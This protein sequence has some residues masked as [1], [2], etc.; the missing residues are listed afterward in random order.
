MKD[1]SVWILTLGFILTVHAKVIEV[2]NAQELIN[3]FTNPVSDEIEL[4][5]DLQFSSSG[6]VYPLGA[7]SDGTCKEFSGILHGN[8]HVIMGLW[9][10]NTDKRN[11]KHGGLFC[12]LQNATIENL[13]ISSSCNFSGHSAGA[14]GVFSEGSLTIRNVR[15]NADVYGYFGSVGGFIGTMK[16]SQQGQKTVLFS[17]CTNDGDVIGN[18]KNAGGFL[19]NVEGTTDLTLTLSNC[20][21][22]GNVI[23]SKN[24]TG[25]FIGFIKSHSMMSVMITNGKNDGDMIGS[26]QNTGGFIGS[27]EGSE[28]TTIT[29][30][31]CNNQ[32]DIIG[33]KNNNGGLIGYINT[34]ESVTFSKG[35]NEGDIIGSRNNTGGLVGSIVKCAN[36]M[37][38]NSTNMGDML[39]SESNV[40]GLVGYIGDTHMTLVSN[41]TNYERVS[42]SE[43][44]VGGIVG[45]VFLSQQQSTTVV[46]NSVNKGN[47]MASSGLG[48]GLICAEYLEGSNGN[49]TVL[50]SMNKKRVMA[51]YAFGI[52][53]KVTKAR[54]VVS[55][56]NMLGSPAYSFWASAED[57][58]LLYGESFKCTNCGEDVTF[59]KK[60]SQTGFY[61][62]VSGS[63]HVHNLL[64]DE[65]K[66]QQ[67][68][69]SW[70]CQLELIDGY[71]DSSSSSSSSSGSEI[72]SMGLDSSESYHPGPTPFPFDAGTVITV[73]PFILMGSLFVTLLFIIF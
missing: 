58:D 20:R 70:A 73:S 11:Y 46:I 24:N 69:M 38:S 36:A 12:S 16:N 29:M 13:V 45:H 17:G 61:D 60:N 39:G 40:G 21:N 71:I 6:L 49:L 63:D 64:N 8:G 44:Y 34:C 55:I 30:T 19:G 68:G 32:G 72:C 27:V 9:M 10:N 7:S 66:A 51:D 52:A 53:N 54:N 35:H 57:A 50:N 25:G 37:I 5:D 43:N 42:G 33:S 62:V 1:F 56:G 47:I 31:N 4:Y 22:N 28:T 14:L 15:N 3:L 65:V 67:Y 2:R 23:G 26:Y 18:E 59:M 41:C 48:C